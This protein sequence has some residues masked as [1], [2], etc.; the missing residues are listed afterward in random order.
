VKEVKQSNYKLTPEQI[1]KAK[2]ERFHG[3]LISDLAKKNNVSRPTMSEALRGTYHK[4]VQ[5][6]YDKAIKNIPNKGTAKLTDEQVLW[7]RNQVNLSAPQI[8]INFEARYKCK[9]PV[10]HTSIRAIK[11]GQTYKWIK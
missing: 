8:A 2:E 3:A 6:K 10:D 4:H 11:R 5:T 1:E 9:C 7:I